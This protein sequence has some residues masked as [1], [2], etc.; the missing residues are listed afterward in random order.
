MDLTSFYSCSL[1]NQQIQDLSNFSFVQ[2]ELLLSDVNNT[3][4]FEKVSVEYKC[5]FISNA[6]LGSKPVAIICT[7][8]SSELMRFTLNKIKTFGLLNDID[9]LVVDDRSTEDI[10]SICDEFG[11]SYLRVDNSKGFNFSTLNNI[12]AKIAYDAGCDT[13]ILWNN[14]LWP[15]D[16]STVKELLKL[17]KYHNSTISGTKLLY[18]KVSWNGSSETPENIKQNFASKS[19][20]YRGTIQFGGGL[21]LFTPQ[22][23]IYSP[24]HNKRFQ[25]K[26]NPYVNCNKPDVFVTG[27]FQIINLKWFIENG[28]LNPSLS[29]NFQDV[30]LCLRAVEQKK[31]VYYFGNNL[32]LYHD[33]SFTISKDKFNKQFLSDNILYG[34][35]WNLERFLKGIHNLE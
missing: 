30:D 21:F 7:K 20:N 1:F 19:Q 13:I 25:D 33:E 27:A 31:L 32:S 8:N 15:D 11:V 16:E 10:K 22:N 34:K 3:S 2:K 24:F 18:P 12:A 26:D 14:D 6:K 4:K 29:K 23:Q 17:H 9:F 5:K 28:G 35:I